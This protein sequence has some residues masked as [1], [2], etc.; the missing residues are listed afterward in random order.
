MRFL[1]DPRSKAILAGILGGGLGWLIAELIIGV[2]KSFAATASFGCLTGMGIGAMFGLAE[3]LAVGSR[4]VAIRGAL[5]GGCLGIVGGG[6]GASLAQASYA[7]SQSTATDSGS[8]FSVE[9]QERLQQAGAKSGEVEIGLF[10]QNSNDLDLHVVDP[11]GERIYFGDRV[12]S[13]R[14]ELDVDRNASCGGNV[15]N[16]PVEHIVWPPGFAPSGK[17]IVQVDYFQSCSSSNATAFSV[18]I[19]AP[20]YSKTIEGQISSD[21]HFKT[22]DEFDLGGPMPSMMVSQKTF[23]LLTRIIGWSL[24]GLLL[25]AGQGFVRQSSEAV[26]NLTLGGTIGGAAGGLGFLLVSALLVPAGF[27]DAI[28]R[29]LGMAI[30]GS[31]IGLCMV[32]A[33]QALSAAIVITSG[34][35]EGRRISLDRPQLRLGRNELFEIYLGGDPKIA[36]HHCTFLRD[37][38]EFNVCAEQGTVTV[39]GAAVSQQKLRAGD[40]LQIGNTS[41]AF[42]TQSLDITSGAAPTTIVAKVSSPAKQ[43]TKLVPLPPPPG[44]KGLALP[45]IPPSQAQ[46]V[47]AT[48]GASSSSTTKPPQSLSPATTQPRSADSGRLMPPPPPPSPPP[49]KKS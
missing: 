14:G 43:V 16:K 46:K 29:L 44:V 24:F 27:G 33:E 17:Y 21:E 7:R 35:Y 23:G 18:T 6:A 4:I 49:P 42:V 20:G 22:V 5:I 32:I 25:G 28:S 9:E 1:N 41:L 10:W 12:S 31:A 2:P 34:R 39:N 36:Q 19:G 38:K 11:R 13:T 48:F 8:V 15:T 40:R 47:P 26:R 3:G 45:A 37:G 30:L